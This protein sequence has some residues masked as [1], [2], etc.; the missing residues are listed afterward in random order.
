MKY[1]IVILFLF[2]GSVQAQTGTARTKA[3]LMTLMA[4][5]TTGAISPQDIRDFIQTMFTPQE[6]ITITGVLTATGVTAGSAVLSEAE[7]E[8]LDGAT[9]TTTELNYVDGVTSAIQTQL[10]TKGVIDTLTWNWGII[11]TVI[12]GALPGWKVPYAIT[13]IDV[14]AYTDAN[15][16]TFNLEERA[17]TTPN[18]AGTDAMASD[19]VA[20]TNEQVQTSFSNADFAKGT[21]M[22]PV[23]SATGDVSIFG[24]TAR[25]IKQ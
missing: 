12:T 6:A 4:N 19:L 23:I 16:T 5:N 22:T 24:I 9:L 2:F 25:Y 20:D 15:T 3:A 10:D 13:I 14:S 21:R 18:T 11:D 7:L 17:Q 1:F 8:I